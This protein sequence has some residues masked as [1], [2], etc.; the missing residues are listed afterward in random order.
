M[1][2]KQGN[3]GFQW[4][5]NPRGARPIAAIS[6]P[7]GTGPWYYPFRRGAD[8]RGRDA[9]FSACAGRAQVCAPR[10]FYGAAELRH[11]PSTRDLFLLWV[12][13]TLSLKNPL[14]GSA[15]NPSPFCKLF[16]L[17]I[18]SRSTAKTLPTS[19][20]PLRVPDSSPKMRLLK[21]CRKQPL[22]TNRNHT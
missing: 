14:P 22:K 5:G 13:D 9:S 6:L 10:T 11:E 20:R 18:N 1:D 2:M 17:Q 21:N 16:L 12:C 8:C 4:D 19:L 3:D 15:N 7:R